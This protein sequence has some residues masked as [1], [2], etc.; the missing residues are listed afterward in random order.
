MLDILSDITQELNAV[1][2]CLITYSEA[3]D[4][5]QSNERDNDTPMDY[6]APAANYVAT[7]TARISSRRSIEEMNEAVSAL[8]IHPASSPHAH[9]AEPRRHPLDAVPTPNYGTWSSSHVPAVQSKVSQ[10]LQSSLT[11]V[12][13]KN[14][15]F[16]RPSYHTHSSCTADIA[17]TD[18][19]GAGNRRAC[20][21]PACEETTVS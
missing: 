20:R 19:T 13:T 16:G 6:F 9:R 5:L 1:K 7:L 4:I 18:P 11:L 8:S 14:T 10:R 3:L 12:P 2:V 21:V 17:A 15:R